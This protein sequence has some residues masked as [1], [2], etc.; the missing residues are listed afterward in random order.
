MSLNARVRWVVCYDIRDTSRG[1]RVLRFMQSQGMPLQYS[2][3]IVEAS[4]AHMHRLMIE[5]EALIAPAVDDVRAYRWP[6]P[7]EAHELGCPLVPEGLVIRTPETAPPVRTTAK[8]RR[9]SA[10][11]T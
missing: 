8:M 3:F 5:L 9:A 4:A 7:A 1:L 10:Q 2:V 6:E 11:A